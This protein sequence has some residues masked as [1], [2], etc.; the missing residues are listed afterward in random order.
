MRHERHRTPAP[1][2]PAEHDDTWIVGNSATLTALAQA[3]HDAFT[4]GEG[5]ADAFTADGF[6]LRVRLD[7]AP[8]SLASWVRRAVP[9]TDESAREHR[10]EAVWPGETDEASS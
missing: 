10:P 6:T 7:D 3:I 5:S 4:W 2:C 9:Y 1:L 8:M